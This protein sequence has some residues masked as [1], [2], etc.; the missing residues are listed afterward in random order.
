MHRKKPPGNSM[1][2]LLWEFDRE[3]AQGE[4]PNWTSYVERCRTATDRMALLGDMIRAETDHAGWNSK[5]V[6]ARLQFYARHDHSKVRLAK[7]I[8]ALYSDRITTGSYPPR[9]EFGALGVPL[10]QLKLR[11]CNELLC[12]GHTVGR[13]FRLEQLLGIGGFG[14][15]YRAMDLSNKRLV[16]VKTIHGKDKAAKRMARALLKEEGAALR[17]LPHEGIP[18]LIETLNERNTLCLIIEFVDGGTLWDLFKRGRV[19]AARAARI[20]AAIADA[21]DFAHR[22]KYIHR[23]LKLSNVLIDAAERPYLVD[24]GLALTDESQFD[25]EGETGGSLGYM[26]IES[27][28]GMTRQLDGRTDIWS[29]GVILYELL[30]GRELT[31]RDSRESAF[32]AAVVLDKRR[33]SFPKDVPKALRKICDKCLARDPNN[34]YHTASLLRADLLRFLAGESHGKAQDTRRSG[35]TAARVA[36]RN[37]AWVGDR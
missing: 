4:N 24:F 14:V 13:R 1:A 8:Q 22:K 31:V 18:R 5:R 34:R 2:D 36:G 27:L 10:K 6:R 28:L 29:A 23:D 25:R 16:A 30:T 35:A 21:L 12:L 32:V 20:V 7:L 37:K 9:A 26:P 11:A 15:V 3:L 17:N 33:L 19:S